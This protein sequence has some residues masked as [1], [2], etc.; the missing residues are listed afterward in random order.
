MVPKQSADSEDELPTPEDLDTLSDRAKVAYAVRCA[1]R[2]EPLY[3]DKDDDRARATY[4][5][6][7]IEAALC[8]LAGDYR[9]L[10]RFNEFEMFAG[11]YAASA[12]TYA[13]FAAEESY[14]A[15]NDP[16]YDAEM[17]ECDETT[18]AH[19]AETVARFSLLAAY[20]SHDLIDEARRIE[21]V[22]LH[23][24]LSDFRALAILDSPDFEFRSLGPLWPDGVP[25]TIVQRTERLKAVLGLDASS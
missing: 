19:R 10:P 15:E 25:E 22:A 16:D 14:N 8:Y 1:Q 23:A 4:I 11:N 7:A 18:P 21:R 5:R 24:A 12:A 2:A 13:Y 9:G 20:D 17:A 6:S 3:I